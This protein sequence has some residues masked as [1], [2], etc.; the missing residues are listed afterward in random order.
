MNMCIFP[1]SI[2]GIL[3]AYNYCNVSYYCNAMILFRLRELETEQNILLY[4]I[5][6]IQF[7]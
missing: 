3:N 4:C 1:A 2:L 6:N 7:K 5:N